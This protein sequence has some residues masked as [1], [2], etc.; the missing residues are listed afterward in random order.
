MKGKW[1]AAGLSA[2]GMAPEASLHR[3]E[4]VAVEGST[5]DL[6]ILGA[7]YHLGDLL[8]FTAV[9]RAF[10]AAHASVL[11]VV[12]LPDREISR[13]LEHNPAVDEL[14]YGDPEG[15][16]SDL[17]RR[18]GP[19]LTVHD[20]RSLPIARAMVG[21]WRRYLPWLYYRDLW[22]EP[23]GQ[24][25][26]TFLGL[27]RLTDFR[28]TLCLTDEDRVAALSMPERYVVLAPHI[29]RYTLPMAAAFWYK[30]KGWPSDRW[31]ALAER[32]RTQGYPPV[33]L[34]ASGQQPIP[35]TAPALGFPIRQV[36]GIVERASALV[37]VES[38]LWFVASALDTPFVVVP[39]W[40]PRSIDWPGPTAARYAR[41]FRGRDS[42]DEVLT[43]VN[44]L[45]D[46]D[47]TK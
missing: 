41:I 18:F 26:A 35:G 25:L 31:V 38:G 14:R 17:Q 34:A 27:G 42:V 15:V 9:L 30:M 2:T 39:W 6:F 11:L 44:G 28:P 43:S 4:R 40:L 46:D 29:G 20:L 12:C 37:T 7:D 47:G 13:I 16:R 5:V 1:F 45:I 24:W 3:P 19:R 32:L 8:W 22:L 21:Q 23:R 36:A 33:T 10:R